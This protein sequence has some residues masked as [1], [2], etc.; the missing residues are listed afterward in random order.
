MLGLVIGCVCRHHSG[1]RWEHVDV[2]TSLE[3]VEDNTRDVAVIRIL[4]RSPANPVD[5]WKST[6]RSA[7]LSHVLFLSTSH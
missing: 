1:C 2:S 6:C 5:C 3:L 4:L 7:P